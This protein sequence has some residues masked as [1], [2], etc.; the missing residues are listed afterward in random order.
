MVST[1]DCESAS[2]D[3]SSIVHPKED[4]IHMNW[5]DIKF[6]PIN[7]WSAPRLSQDSP[8]PEEHSLM[9]KRRP[10]ISAIEYDKLGLLGLSSNLVKTHDS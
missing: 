3:S 6:P 2:M 10:I 8:S 5:E 1:V 9:V 4:S 7:L